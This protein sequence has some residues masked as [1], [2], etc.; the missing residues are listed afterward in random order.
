[1]LILSPQQSNNR[2]SCHHLYHVNLEI[3]SQRGEV[4]YMAKAVDF[5]TW[6]L[7]DIH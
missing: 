2:S 1:M 6:Q 7:V 3:E 5:N 4:T